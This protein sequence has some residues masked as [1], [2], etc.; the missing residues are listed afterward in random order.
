VGSDIHHNGHINVFKR[1]VTIKSLK[2]LEIAIEA[3]KFF[4]YDK[5]N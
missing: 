1:P 3:N 2:A 5:N 4:K